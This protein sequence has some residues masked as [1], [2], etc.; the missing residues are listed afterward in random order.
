MNKWWG[1]T[2][3]VS[4]HEAGS[5]AWKEQ[6]TKSS[7]SKNVNQSPTRTGDSEIESARSPQEAGPASEATSRRTFWGGPRP[8][9][10]VSFYWS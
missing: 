3:V 5:A 1:S 6:R 8:P 10:S 7:E 9:A 4:E 2:K